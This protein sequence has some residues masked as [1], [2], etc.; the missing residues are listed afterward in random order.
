MS[1]N[2]RTRDKI[3]RNK[4]WAYKKDF[5]RNRYLCIDNHTQIIIK[6]IKIFD[7]NTEQLD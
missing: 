6:S 4:V 5:V 2:I 7:G 3:L 1:H